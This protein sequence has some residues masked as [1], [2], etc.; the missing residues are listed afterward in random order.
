MSK[1]II[2]TKV[3]DV[4]SDIYSPS[5]TS[6]FLPE[7]Y[8]KTSSYVGNNKKEVS[9]GFDTNA[10]IKRCMPVFDVLTAGYIIPTY[11]DLWISKMP[12]GTIAYTTSSSLNI[13][14]H[15]IIQAPYHPNM[16]DHP[17]PKWINPWSIKTPKGYSCLFLPPV[18]SGNNYFTILEG[19]VDTDRYT[20][21]VNFPFVLND[22]NFEGLIPSGTPMVQV[23]PIKRESWS[24][25]FGGE[26]D[27]KS[28]ISTEIDLSTTF[29]DRYK[30]LFWNK[31]V[32]R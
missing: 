17:Y 14:H 15:G 27:L 16:N 10:T 11:C 30:R 22:I 25:S 13:S 20:S 2:F 1:D 3:I 9:P 29:F 6:N 26:K 12:D 18:H 31:K 5:P 32:Y 4:V 23:I 19:L 8:K 28:A 7:W 21:P 24:M